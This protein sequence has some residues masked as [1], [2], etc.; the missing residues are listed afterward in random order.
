MA[1]VDLDNRDPQELNSHVKVA[2]EDV[3]GEPESARSIDCIWINSYKCFTCGKNCMYKF[4]STICG[5]C[6]ALCWGCEF[7]RLAFLHVWCCTPCIRCYSLNLGILQRCWGSCLNCFLIPL[8][9]ACSLCLSN[10][11]FMNK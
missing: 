1:D 2:F 8:C 4:L 3:L 9:E 6:I 11:P 7:A 5:I 10:A